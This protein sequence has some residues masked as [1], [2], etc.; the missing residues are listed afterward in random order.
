MSHE[1]ASPDTGL[2][3]LTTWLSPN[4]PVGGYS[5]SHGLEAA[6]E[7]GAVHDAASLQAW[8]TAVLR[9]GAGISDGAFL[10]HAHRA[11]G[12]PAALA[13]IHDLALAFQPTAELALETRAQGRAFLRTTRDAWPCDALDRLA[14]LSQ[15]PVAYPVAVGVAAGGHGVALEP[16][17]TVYLGAFAGSLVSAALRLLPVGQSAGQ[18]IL[19]ELAPTVAATA[20]EAQ[21]TPLEEIATAVPMAELLAIAHE[22][23]TTRLFRS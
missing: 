2:Y 22:H 17:L 4:Y 3:R 7:A 15:G 13:E 9:D 8:L 5:F 18:R 10:A 20:A 19:A 12:D 14:G 16:A 1:P 21:A 23:Q 6:A 11:C